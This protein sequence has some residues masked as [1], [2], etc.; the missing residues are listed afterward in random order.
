[1]RQLEVCCGGYA[2]AIRAWKAGA[3][4]IELC[5]SLFLGGITPSV[6]ALTLIKKKT[7]LEVICIVRPRGAGFIY[8][9][10]EFEQMMHA[11]QCL[12]EAGAD[13]ISFGFLDEDFSLDNTR[14]QQMTILIHSY[15]K[16]AIFH[17][18]FDVL[19]NP[20]HNAKLL[21]SHGVDGILTSG[22]FPT[23]QEGISIIKEMQEQYGDKIKITA[24]AG[25]NVRNAEEILKK[26]GVPAIHSTCKSW[27]GD[28]TTS[29]SQ[30][31]FAYTRNNA[32]EYVDEHKV[33]AL[34]KIV[35]NCDNE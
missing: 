10:L 9:D 21:I 8:D 33:K 1:M 16:E 4:R 3:K 26:T 13:G 14:I 22:C 35:E 31:S 15:G 27:K 17:R 29:S 24:A 20:L 23:A 5:S 18:A 2:D 28:P 34:L 25:V 11:A 30:M 32:Y 19:R 6:G 7:D 12:L